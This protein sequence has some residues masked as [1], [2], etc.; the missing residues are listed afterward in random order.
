MILLD[1]NIL[2]YAS[3]PSSIYSVW[4][5]ETIAKAVDTDGASIDA[6]SLA[7]VCVGDE[8]PEAVADNIRSWGIEILD[9][10]AAAAVVC[11]KAY[12][13]YRKRRLSQ[14]QKDSPTVPLP[15]FF[16]GAHSQIMGW[17]L[18]TADVGRFKT[19]FPSIKLIT[20]VVFKEL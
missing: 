18:A 9:S 17:S 1:T 19:Y 2:I 10:P 14:S 15:D 5:R 4:A 13:A 11:A 20:P 16:I 12:R 7:E 3:D 8:F 6:V